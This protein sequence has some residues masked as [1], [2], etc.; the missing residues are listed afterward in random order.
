[1]SLKSKILKGRKK[2]ETLE[3]IEKLQCELMA[4]EDLRLELE[5]LYTEQIVSGHSEHDT[6]I[7]IEETLQLQ[8]K[9]ILYLWQ[10]YKGWPDDE[11]GARAHRAITSWK[12]YDE[13]HRYLPPTLRRY[14]IAGVSQVSTPPL[15]PYYVN[16][17]FLSKLSACYSFPGAVVAHVG[18]SDHCAVPEEKYKKDLIRASRYDFT[19]IIGLVDLQPDAKK[20]FPMLWGISTHNPTMFN[21]TQTKKLLIPE[22]RRLRRTTKNIYLRNLI[23]YHCVL[24]RKVEMPASLYFIDG[25]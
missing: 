17:L 8:K 9:T 6:C 19:P 25:C 11:V 23:N 10:I 5:R 24:F 20:R 21:E 14:S 4:Q 15:I 1:M 18:Y 16:E 2:A 22:L 12:D 7:K 13:K 3:R